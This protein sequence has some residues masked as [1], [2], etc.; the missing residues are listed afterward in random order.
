MHGPS[1]PSLA[2][3]QSRLVINRL[4]LAGGPRSGVLAEIYVG[5]ARYCWQ[6][7]AAVR[8]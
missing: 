2:A 3:R 7:K 5:G 8:R 1:L 6:H 4:I